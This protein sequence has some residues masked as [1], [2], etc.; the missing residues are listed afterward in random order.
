MPQR[1]LV[2]HL[3]VGDL[4][5]ERRPQPVR[6]AD[7]GPWGLNGGDRLLEWLHDLHQAIQLGGIEPGPDLS[8]IAKLAL[9]VDAEDHRAER[10]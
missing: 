10:P 8:G 4:G 2:G 5:D 6:A 9:L 3:R 7:F 1:A